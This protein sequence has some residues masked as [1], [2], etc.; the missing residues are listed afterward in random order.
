[1]LSIDITDKQVRIARGVQQGGGVCINDIDTREISDGAVVNGYLIDIA[2][3]SGEIV[4]LITSKGITEKE[5]TVVINSSSILNKEIEIPRP[6]SLKN[7]ATIEAMVAAQMGVTNE[8]IVTYSV[9]KD[10]V[11]DDGIPTLKL[12]AYACPEKMVESYDTL[13]TQLGFKQKHIMLSSSCLYRMFMN[14]PL[15]DIDPLLT[16]QIESDSVNISLFRNGEP[17]FSRHTLVDASDYAGNA[18]YMNIAAFDNLFRILQYIAQ[19]P[20]NKPVREIVF[21]GNIPDFEA[22]STMVAS[23]NIPVSVAETPP[24]VTKNT[25][26]E[27]SEYLTAVCAFLKYDPLRDH[28]DMKFDAKAK[29]GAGAN[30]AYFAKLG[31]IALGCIV[32]VGGAYFVFDKMNTDITKEITKID[33]DIADKEERY[34]VLVKKVAIFDN[35][36][37]YRYGVL[38]AHLLFDFQPYETSQISNEINKSIIKVRAESAAGDTGIKSTI[39]LKSVTVDLYRVTAQFTCSSTR[40]P[41]MLAEQLEND[42]YFDAVKYRGYDVSTSKDLFGTVAELP[43]PQDEKYIFTIEMRLKGGHAYDEKL[44]AQDKLQVQ[45]KPQ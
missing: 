14:S 8:Y 26:F 39:K 23:F 4:E 41:S 7:F 2:M 20:D 9:L 6:K 27:F 17:V 43:I 5:V 22:L 15:L 3:V 44:Q 32:I 13:L 36:E 12:Q 29:S 10:F 31:A 11:S 25:E 21:Y 16:V 42:G 45:D 37:L 18:E 1:M 30:N 38:S 19:L 35:F 40:V 33:A 28:V 34:Q 24:C